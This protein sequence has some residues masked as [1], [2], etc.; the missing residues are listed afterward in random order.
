MPSVM[1][2]PEIAVQEYQEVVPT[3]PVVPRGRLWAILASLRALLR[4]RRVSA[5]SCHEPFETGIEM[6]ARKH[7]FIFIGSFSG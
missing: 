5:T 2:A 7:P 6:L 1:E 4:S 3:T